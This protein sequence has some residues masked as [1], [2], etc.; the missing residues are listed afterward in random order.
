[1]CVYVFR[2]IFGDDLMFVDW[3]VGSFDFV[4]LVG[5]CLVGCVDMGICEGFG[6]VCVLRVWNWCL[7][8]SVC[9]KVWKVYFWIC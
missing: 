5:C 9:L 3:E 4:E 6:Y 1:M 8:Y 2:D 7:N